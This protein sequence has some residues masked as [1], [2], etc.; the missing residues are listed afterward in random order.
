[1]VDCRYSVEYSRRAFQKG[2]IT[3]RRRY[4]SPFFLTSI[5]EERIAEECGALSKP[6]ACSDAKVV[7]YE[8]SLL[9]QR[10]FDTTK[11]L[12]KKVNSKIRQ[13]NRMAKKQST[14]KSKLKATLSEYNVEK[15]Y[16]R[17]VRLR[18][19][20]DSLTKDIRTRHVAL[21]RMGNEIDQLEST[22]RSY[23]AEIKRL[24]RNY[25]LAVHFK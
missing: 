16:D 23:E 4:S 5:S 22:I 6:H 9:A 8:K 17:L 21:T 3:I 19:Q 18:K 11:P 2:I 13:Y 12:I 15:N 20:A 7:D 10:Y 24:E 14:Q 1:M 25:P